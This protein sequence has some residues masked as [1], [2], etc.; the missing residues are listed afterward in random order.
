MSIF[1]YSCPLLINSN[2][3]II[4][5]LNTLLIKCSRPIL[6]YESYKYNTTAIMKKLNWS[7]V[8][9]M[10]MIESC[11]FIHKCIFEGIP[12]T[13]N[14]LITFSINREK[15]VRSIRKPLIRIPCNSVKANQSLIYQAVFLYNK[16]PD[17]YR[18]YNINKFKKYTNIFIK[19]NFANNDIPKNEVT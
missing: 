6:G 11:I 13:I 17:I 12:T 10:L 19:E 4:N 7:T 1:K 18:T 2:K 9:H 14:E 16:L 5:K 15:N 8:H 3:I